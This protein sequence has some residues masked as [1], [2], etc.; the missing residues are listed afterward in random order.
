MN[1]LNYL[2]RE[3]IRQDCGTNEATFSDKD[4]DPVIEEV[5]RLHAI[6]EFKHTRV[7]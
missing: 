7:Y 3:F 2:T 6:K 5:K 1:N 4:Y